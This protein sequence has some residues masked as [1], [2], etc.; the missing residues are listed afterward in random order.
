MYIGFSFC[1]SLEAEDISEELDLTLTC[2]VCLD[3]V[4]DCKKIAILKE[5]GHSYHFR[6]LSSWLERNHSCPICRNKVTLSVRDITLSNPTIA[7]L[8]AQETVRRNVPQKSKPKKQSRPVYQSVARN[9]EDDY[10]DAYDYSRR[11]ELY[12]ARCMYYC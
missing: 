8:I 7:R 5:C 2:P 3:T 1:R 12:M 6:C 4:Q 9:K 10:Y 11:S